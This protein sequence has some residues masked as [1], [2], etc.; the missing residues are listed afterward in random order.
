MAGRWDTW[1]AAM[2]A[3]GRGGLHYPQLTID[4]GLAYSK[5]I[6]IAM[7]VSG[8]DFVASLRESPDAPDPTL[9]NF[10]VTVGAYA[11]GVT[12]V[13]LELTEEETG[14]L[15]A[16]ADFDGVEAFPFDLLRNGARFMAGTI[17]VVGKVT[18][19]DGS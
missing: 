16:D 13:T 9:I 19:A 14:D 6:A 7:D 3:A 10:A 2:K 17:P 4:R 8:D 5:A 11:D 15:P 18:N 12:P 1:L